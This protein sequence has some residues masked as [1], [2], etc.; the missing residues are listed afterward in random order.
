MR[1]SSRFVRLVTSA[2]VF[3]VLGTGGRVARAQVA[4]DST[5]G[6]HAA[7]TT[8]TRDRA[9]GTSAGAPPCARVESRTTLAAFSGATIRTLRIETHAPAPLPGAAAMVGRL[10]VT[11]R[12][13]TVQ[14]FLPFAAGD[15]IDT[16][17]LG[18]ALRRLRRL[19]Y[20]TDAWVEGVSCNDSHQMDLVVST[21]DGWSV[22]PSVKVRSNV[23]SAIG[24]TERNLLGTGRE[25]TL[26]VKSN[27]GR[28]GVGAAVRDPW[29]LGDRVSLEAGT[30]GYVDGGEQY[31]TLGKR[32]Q[33]VI[34]R[35]GWA[36]DLSRSVREPAS[37]IGDAFERRRASLL[38]SRRVDVS[39]AAATAVVFGGEGESAALVA[40]LDAPI[41][42]PS[43]VRRD[44][45]GGA[46]G[47]T[48]RSIAFDTLSWLLPRLALVDVPSAFE[49]DLLLGVGRDA[50]SGRPASRVDL[51]AGRAWK[52]GAR[53]LVV[54]DAWG[55]G[56][57]TG[58]AVQGATV[59][60]SLAWYHAASHGVWVGRLSGERLSRPDPDIRAL[61][62]ADPTVEAL[63]E[64]AR[65]AK[66]ALGASLERDWRIRSV[67][68]SWGVDG[69]LFGAYSNRWDLVPGLPEQLHAGVIGAGLRM[70]PARLGR[71]TA[72][73]DLAYPVVRSPA[74]RQR[75]FVSISITPW[76]EQGRQRDGREVR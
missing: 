28:V 57:R 59:R 62:L 47:L 72:R 51:W 22:R 48:R 36:L 2:A 50:V 38:L 29:F 31:V 13:R 40:A 73:L 63:P 64:R 52:G 14:R 43:R 17:A 19:R 44:F 66:S 69:A 65:L 7:D 12:E 5:R 32:E 34:D 67:S 30:N 35:S 45:V 1:S 58:T 61:V 37:G 71:A 75:P 26:G 33:R 16:L 24:I 49:V 42:G 68:R 6:A 46:I 3:L 8:A 27:R 4:G 25:V 11:T 41:V 55:G 54:A 70:V 74:V 20:L 76:F 53:S 10:H 21:R 18:E 15:T 9:D 60:T 23:S 39:D 56:Y